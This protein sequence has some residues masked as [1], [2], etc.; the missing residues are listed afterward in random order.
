MVRMLSGL[1]MGILDIL[2][3][4]WGNHSRRH[5]NPLNLGYRGPH[6]MDQVALRLQL[7]APL[8]LHQLDLHQQGPHQMNY[9]RNQ[10]QAS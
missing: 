3:V 9:Q 7:L 2:I 10:R 5:R 4:H 6:Q 1:Q 8:G